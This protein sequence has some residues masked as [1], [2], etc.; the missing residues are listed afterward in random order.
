MAVPF[1]DDEEEDN[2]HQEQ[3]A[4][5]QNNPEEDDDR[6]EVPVFDIH[7]VTMAFDEDVADVN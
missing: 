1:F 2:Q 4:H 7:D 6:L 5:F 3:N